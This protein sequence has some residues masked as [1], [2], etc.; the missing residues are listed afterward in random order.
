VVTPFFPP[1]PFSL[2]AVLSSQ[3]SARLAARGL[4]KKEKKKGRE[5]SEEREAKKLLKNPGRKRK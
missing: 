5:R 3:S 1:L 2:Q 4:Y